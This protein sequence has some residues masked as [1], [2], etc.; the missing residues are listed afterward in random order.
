VSPAALVLEHE[1]DAPAGLLGEWAQ[2]RGIALEV[3]AAGAPLPDPDGRPFVVSLGS[4]ASAF[5]DRVPWLA[6]ERALLDRALLA[7]VPILGICFGAQHLARALG[8]VVS[9][10]SRP[11]VGWLDVET[12]APGVVAPGAW[13][14]WHRDAFTLPPGAELLA[15][16]EVCV[17]AFR[18]GPHL[19]VQFHPEV[20]PAIAEG[21]ARDYPDSM[22]R[23]GT[24]LATVRAGAE[25]HAGGARVRA[26]ALF[27]AF[28]ASARSAPRMPA[29]AL[30]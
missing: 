5:D 1:A 28:L 10:A 14:Q 21:W 26:F 24:D 7:E 20:T 23:A 8:G 13:L 27:D 12:L 18:R 2:A 22:V 17:Q 11:E 3:V 29:D 25:A 9:S 15:R 19:G 6:A 16:S 4:E 30:G